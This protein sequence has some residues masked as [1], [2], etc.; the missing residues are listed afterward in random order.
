MDAETL[1]VS[2]LSREPA[3]EKVL[4]WKVG[5]AISREADVILLRKGVTTE[6]RVDIAGRKVE[7]WKERKDAQAAF[8]VSEFIG[9]G[10]EA[11]SD[12]RI[13]EALSKHGIKDLTTVECVPLPFGHFALPEL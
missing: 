8:F 6:V 7:S 5:E 11:K 2:V 9:L 4:A 1:C 13:R 3:K 10:E 12:P